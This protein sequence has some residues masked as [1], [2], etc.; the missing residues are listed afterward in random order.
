MRP[1][2]ENLIL[3]SLLIINDPDINNISLLNLYTE[4]LL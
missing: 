2:F 4:T 1:N 3:Q